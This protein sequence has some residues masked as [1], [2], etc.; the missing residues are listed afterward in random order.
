MMN[1][2]PLSAQLTERQRH[3]M[4]LDADQVARSLGFGAVMPVNEPFPETAFP[5]GHAEN[6]AASDIMLDTEAPRPEPK[7]PL[8]ELAMRRLRSLTPHTPE[9]KEEIENAI[10]VFATPLA[11]LDQL[12]ERV[13][14]EHFSAIDARWERIRKEG[15]ELLDTIIPKCEKAVYRWQQQAQKTSEAKAQRA[16]DALQCLFERQK[17]SEWA[18]ASEIAAADK[19]KANAGDASVAAAALALEDQRGLAAAE[20][21]LATATGHLQKLKTELHRLQAELHGQVYFDTTLGLSRD[22]LSHRAK[23]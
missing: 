11:A 6:D 16:A 20:S 5:I 1:Q 10:A 15:R 18:S 4:Q 14:Q 22:P 2:K 21:A 3:D 8:L 12:V 9:L 23:W 19:R 13:E 17:I 7:P